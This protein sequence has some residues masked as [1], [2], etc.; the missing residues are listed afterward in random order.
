MCLR[1]NTHTSSCSN[2][3]VLCFDVRACENTRTRRYTLSYEFLF[4]CFKNNV[5][6]R[7]CFC[8]LNLDFT[9]TNA[10]LGL[11]SVCL[12][13]L[14]RNCFVVEHLSKNL[15]IKHMLVKESKEKWLLTRCSCGL[16]RKNQPNIVYSLKF[17]FFR[18]LNCYLVNEQ[19]CLLWLKRNMRG[20]RVCSYLLQII[21]N[22]EP[23]SFF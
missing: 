20:R 17:K 19:I 14:Q 15:S 6:S 7:V 3:L 11:S 18:H 2:Y 4:S 10:N 9:N 21:K 12:R 22:V 1:E 5:L 8:E 23:R 13:F 16:P